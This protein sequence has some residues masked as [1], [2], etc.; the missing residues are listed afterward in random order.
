MTK[1]TVKIK[2]Q[3]PVNPQFFE[4]RNINRRFFL[5]I[6]PGNSDEQRKNRVSKNKQN[7][8]GFQPPLFRTFVQQKNESGNSRNKQKNSHPIYRFPAF[9]QIL[10]LILRL[11]LIL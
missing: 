4:H 10:S 5:V 8:I 6:F 2:I 1:L 9:A 7:K 3:E 11:V